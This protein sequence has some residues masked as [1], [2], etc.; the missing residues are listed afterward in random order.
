[1]RYKLPSCHLCTGT[2]KIKTAARLKINSAAFSIT[3]FLPRHNIFNEAV[4]GGMGF[5]KTK[6][7][8]WE[9]MW[10][11]YFENYGGWC[12]IVYSSNPGK[13]DRNNRQE[14]ISGFENE[15]TSYQAELTG[16]TEP[17]VEILHDSSPDNAIQYSMEDFLKP[18]EESPED[19]FYPVDEYMASLDDEI[20]KPEADAVIENDTAQSFAPEY[21]GKTGD[22]SESSANLDCK[23]KAYSP[24]T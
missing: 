13:K 17:V 23:K 9:E 12:Y 15:I 5:M 10:E 19:K 4:T 20:H 14:D 2:I 7:I 8:K 1:M 24:K 16:K 3:F 6:R 18:P 11:E 21:V 22:H